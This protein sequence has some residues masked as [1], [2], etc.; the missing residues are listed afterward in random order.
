MT[1]RTVHNSIR[2]ESEGAFIDSKDT[3]GVERD[4]LRGSIGNGAMNLEGNHVLSR[5]SLSRRKNDVKKGKCVRIVNTNG[6]LGRRSVVFQIESSH[7]LAV[8]VGDDA[9]NVPNTHV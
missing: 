2:V 6:R 1:E 3:R 4:H 8:E 9:T 7:F 5:N